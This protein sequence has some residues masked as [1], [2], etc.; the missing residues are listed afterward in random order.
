MHESKEMMIF[1]IRFESAGIPYMITGS[2][3]GTIYGEPR[4]T[5]DIDLVVRLQEED[6]ARLCDVFGPNEFYLPPLEV[7]RSEAQRDSLGH[8]NIIDFKGGVKA[9][10]YPLGSDALNHWAF[11]QRRQYD[12]HGTILWVAPVE[13]VI[14]RKLQ[15]YQEGKSE[16]HIRDI[17]SMLKISA[18]EIDQQALQ[19]KL[20]ENNLMPLW[21]D[22]IG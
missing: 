10:I 6:I 3:A 2:I 5:N 13:Y 20:K 14:I 11:T 16:K 15:F 22:I 9:D 19:E 7:I 1:P 12:Y 18:D 21:Q 4:F 8:F 17:K